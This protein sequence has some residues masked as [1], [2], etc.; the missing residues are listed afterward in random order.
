MW[1]QFKLTGKLLWHF[2]F[3]LCEFQISVYFVYIIICCEQ[4]TK[5]KLCAMMWTPIFFKKI[6]GRKNHVIGSHTTGTKNHDKIMGSHTKGTKNHDKIMGSHTKGT[7]NHDK[8]MGSHTKGTKNHD[9]IMRSHAKGTK[10]H[11]K[12]MGSQLKGKI[13]QHFECKHIFV[14][15]SS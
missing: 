8:I 11:D 4:F 14:F 9:K 2:V 5:T 1:L 13:E 12:I 15:I 3:V 6:K 10:N 7:K